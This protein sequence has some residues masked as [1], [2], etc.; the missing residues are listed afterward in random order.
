[1]RPEFLG[2]SYDVVKCFFCATL[3]SLGYTVYIDP[4]F[5]G[6]WSGQQTT[7]FHFLGVEP[8]TS[9]TPPSSGTAL[10]LDPDTGRFLEKTGSSRS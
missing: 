1:M 2:D 10:F 4:L 7:F 9:E 3:R 8:L 5:T 6:I